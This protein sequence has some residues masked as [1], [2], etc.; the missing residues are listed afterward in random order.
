MD[1]RIYDV[2]FMDGSLQQLVENRVVLSMYEYIYYEGF[3]IK[4]IDSIEQHRKTEDTFDSLDAF[5][6]DSRGRKSRRITVLECRFKR[7]LRS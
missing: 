5:V 3:T 1:T 4:I 6:I 2:I 7:L